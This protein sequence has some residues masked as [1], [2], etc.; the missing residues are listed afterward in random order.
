MGATR[1]RLLRP[2]RAWVT[3]IAQTQG[4]ALG[5]RVTLRWS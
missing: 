2:F 3:D 4:V 1:R 5:Y